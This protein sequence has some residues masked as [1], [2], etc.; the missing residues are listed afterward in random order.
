MADDYRHE[1]DSNSSAK[2]NM[3]RYIFI[4]IGALGLATLLF[5]KTK[6]KE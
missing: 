6:K 1:I 4:G 3:M 5:I 2:S